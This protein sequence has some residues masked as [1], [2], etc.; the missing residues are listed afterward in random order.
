MGGR[1]VKKLSIISRNENET[2]LLPGLDASPRLS[3]KRIIRPEMFGV[4]AF[5]FFFDLLV[6]CLP[7]TFEIL[8]YLDR[9]L[10]W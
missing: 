8:S 3:V 6:G 2:L 10:G 4:A 9:A 5:E 7:E 1:K